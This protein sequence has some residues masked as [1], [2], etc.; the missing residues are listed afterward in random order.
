MGGCASDAWLPVGE[1]SILRKLL[2]RTPPNPAEQ[3]RNP[4]DPD[5][6]Y[7][8]TVALTNTLVRP[9]PE[10]VQIFRD[11]IRD[12]DASVRA[13]AARGL[14]THGT[15]D[16]ADLLIEALGDDEPLVRRAAAIG[17]QRV[18]D[19][20]AIDPLLALLDPAA[21]PEATIRVEAALALGQYANGRVVQ[22]LIASLRSDQEQSLAVHRAAVRSLE[23][24]T[25]Q[26]FGLDFA[27]WQ[28]W[29]DGRR[30]LF[31]GQREY[32]YVVFRR[33]PAWYERLPVV[34]DPPNETS[35]T[36]IGLRRAPR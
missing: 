19:P 9:E 16:D 36:P 25:G 35:S 20:A 2:T 14:A 7:R 26:D 4:Y 6:R 24:L 31:E 27:A 1:E 33:S 5:A 22:A 3:A 28:S 10:L 12:R 13:A 21:E 32:T 34:P 29:A 23:L 15:A 30:D 8:G 11:N 18:H 17:L